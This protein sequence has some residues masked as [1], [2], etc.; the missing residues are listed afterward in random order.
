MTPRLKKIFARAE[1]NF[2]AG[3]AL[4]IDELSAKLGLL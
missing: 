1:K 2:K 4:S 3:K